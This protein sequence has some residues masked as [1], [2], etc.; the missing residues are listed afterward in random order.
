VNALPPAARL[1][2]APTFV[3]ARTMDG[4]AYVAKDSEPYTQ[5]WLAERERLLLA[6]FGGR[7]GA[8]V[9]A[10]TAGYFR[11][12]GMAAAPAEMQRVQ[13]AIAGMREAGV[14]LAPAADTS[15][16]DAAMARHYIAH[17]PFPRE[18]AELIAAQGGI[19]RA[20]RV[21]DLAGGPG[22]LALALAAASESVTMMELS[23]GF[24]ATARRRARQRG[25]RLATL[26]DSCNR[27][28]QRDEPF[29]VITV[30]QALHWLD[31]VLVCKGVCRTLAAGGRFFVVHSAIE[32]DDA[33]PLAWL[34]GHDSVLG[35]KPR[36]AFADEAQA[37]RQRVGGL[38][39]AL[40]APQVQRV[41]PA[42]QRGADALAQRIGT[43]GRWLFRQRRPFDAGYARGFLTPAHI[44][45]LGQAP[46]AFWA[47][48]EARCTAASPAQL[49]GTQHWAVLEFRRGAAHAQAVTE[50]AKAPAGATTVDIAYEAP[51][52]DAM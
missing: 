24:L 34:L 51:R 23:R 48:V 27:L 32:L 36:S 1:R 14:L 52:P 26:H 42:Q 8:T 3:M 6:Q 35:A 5:F 45:G 29:D 16:Y 7:S 39:E 12:R 46:G 19:G 49:L 41:D 44:A 28:V 18:L 9:E 47:D 37:L 2:M 40:D 22:D 21:L 50:A 20:T 38:F 43:G 4:R 30:S 25:V 15:R 33:H 10:A 17:R 11:S 31:D 13:R